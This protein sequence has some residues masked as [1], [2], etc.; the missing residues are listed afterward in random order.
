MLHTIVVA[1]K[2]EEEDDDD[3]APKSSNIMEEAKRDSDDTGKQGDQGE[4]E[5]LNDDSSGADQKMVA[6]E[7]TGGQGGVSEV[8]A[9][10]R[11]EEG[12]EAN[13]SAGRQRL[14]SFDSPPVAHLVP[15]RPER[16][17]KEKL[18]ERERQKRIETE[19]ARLKR[20]F[21]L[22]HGGGA[23]A[24][25]EETAVEQE[26]ADE[27][28]SVVGTVGDASSVAAHAT[29]IEDDHENQRRDD[30][31]NND[32]TAKDGQDGGNRGELGY[33]MERFL[34]EQA[35]E[36]TRERRDGETGAGGQNSGVVSGDSTTNNSNGNGNEAN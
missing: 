1:S 19:R 4:N 9:S 27:N 8:S 25:E 33:T 29:E 24:T 22:S 17:L 16:T 14:P 7:A 2:E 3:D 28:G 21:A 31:N 12:E 20:Q 18:V 34:S 10:V 23:S 32:E 6:F 11:E 5:R 30:G 26:Q 13:S 36:S 35:T 15:P